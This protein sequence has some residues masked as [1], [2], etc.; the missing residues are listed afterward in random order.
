M[1]MKKCSTLVINKNNS[2]QNF[3]EIY[4]TPIR[5]AIIKKEYKCWR[6]WDTCALLVVMWSRAAP[7]KRQRKFFKSFKIELLYS[8]AIPHWVYP[9]KKWTQGL[10]ETFTHSCSLQHY[11]QE[12]RGRSNPHVYWQVNGYRKCLA[13]K[14]EGNPG[15]WH[16][17]DEPW[18]HDAK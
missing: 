15:S 16:K 12:P 17:M 14:K 11:M 6:N 13:L 8:S 3:S 7:L 10:W 4:F 5:I 1:L 18:G 9:W 2:N